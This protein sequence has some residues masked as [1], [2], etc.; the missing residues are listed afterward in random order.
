LAMRRGVRMLN[1]G[2]STIAPD[3]RSG[4]HLQK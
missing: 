2:A 3:R 4:F 1:V